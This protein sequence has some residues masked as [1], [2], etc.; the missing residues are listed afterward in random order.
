[1]V[2]KW[3]PKPPASGQNKFERRQTMSNKFDYMAYEP[4]RKSRDERREREQGGCGDP[5]C[6]QC[7]NPDGS[8][9]QYAQRY[10]GNEPAMASPQSYDE[11]ARL[12]R[13]MMSDPRRNYIS[14]GFDSVSTSTAEAKLAEARKPI[15][16]YI[17]SVDKQSVA[18]DDVIGNVRAKEELRDAIEA[19]TKDADLYRFYDMTPPKGVLLW[20][21]PGCGKTMFGKAAATAVGALFGKKSEMLLINGAEIESPILS[22]AG[23]KI[24]A[25]F[26]YARLYKEVHK[27]P[28]VLF[29]DEADALLRSR[30]RFPISTEVVAQ[31]LAELDG[32]KDCGA[33]VILATNQ[34]DDIDEALLRDG[35]CE[36][37]IKVERPDQKAAAAILAHNLRDAP[38]WSQ[39]GDYLIEPLVERLFHNDYLLRELTNPETG[40]NHRF[41]LAHIING[42]ML[43][44]LL[45]RA[46][47]IAFRRDKAE[48]VR[49]GVREADMF[50]AIDLLFEENK[51]L[52]HDFALKE[53]IIDVALPAEA[54][55]NLN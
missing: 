43:V 33:F 7:Y 50:A 12:A 27:V 9:T 6:R 5:N 41:L 49:T 42:A 11:L 44:G 39:V 40:R 36:R 17:Y 30:Q 48:G 16:Q 4:P 23:K 51:G 31:F 47:S 38:Q 55:K 19:S 15:E 22:I 24:A 32:L 21:P 14:G 35:R 10:D 29:I 8:L 20:G 34:P 46:K 2:N 26:E 52:N 13:D 18:W 37:K 45:S 53:F 1:M 25:L 3:K 54:L 28:V